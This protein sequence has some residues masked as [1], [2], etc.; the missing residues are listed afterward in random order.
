MVPVKVHLNAIVVHMH[1]YGSMNVC[2][3]VRASSVPTG[4]CSYEFSRIASCGGNQ[5]IKAQILH[6]RIEM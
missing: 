3:S 2:Y 6:M 5:G 1:V 4:I